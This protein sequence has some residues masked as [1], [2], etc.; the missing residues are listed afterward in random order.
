MIKL[1]I[2]GM[3][4]ANGH[5][6]SWSAIV[7][8]DYDEATMAE[9]GF[10]VIPAYLGSNTDTIGIDD[11]AIT[12]I[13]CAEGRET[14]EHIAKAANIPNVVDKMED[15]IGQ[16]DAVLLA[17]DDPENHVAM[18]KPFIDADVPIFIDKP[19]AF[20][21]EDLNYFAEQVKAGK[22]IMSNSALR[23]SAGLQAVREQRDNIGEIKLCV[24]VG[25]K[26]LRKY[27]IHYLEGLYSF[28]GDPKAT[29]VQHLDE[30]GRNTIRV[31]FETGT[32][33]YIHIC[34]GITSGELNIYG[35]KGHVNVNHGGA[36]TCFRAQLVEFIHSLRVGKP[37]LDFSKTYNLI[38]T[39]VSA[40]ESRDA[41]GTVIEL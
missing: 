8:G 28:L 7:N 1:G 32:I 40:R 16:V 12:H 30:D 34:E 14:S 23:Y 18:A 2:I 26:C 6:Y 39:L 37:R 13:W 11:A 9:C 3:S 31:E 4:E 29:K 25:A 22:F 41:G 15:M 17:R 5:P 35:T 33:A 36:Y 27:A 19:L 21:R 38:N 24:A 20:C 10:P